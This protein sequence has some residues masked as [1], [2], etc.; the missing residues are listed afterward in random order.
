MTSDN[1]DGD[2]HHYYHVEKAVKTTAKED[3]P[4]EY[5]DKRTFLY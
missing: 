1:N 5:R 3:I 4:I 2:H